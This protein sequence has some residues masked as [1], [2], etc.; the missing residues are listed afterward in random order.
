LSCVQKRKRG[1]SQSECPFLN[2]PICR[3][4]GS[5]PKRPGEIQTLPSS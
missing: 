3:T 2:I 4:C 1:N 5:G